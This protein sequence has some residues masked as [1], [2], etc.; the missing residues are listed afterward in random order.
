MKKLFVFALL[1]TGVAMQALAGS[2]PAPV[3]EIGTTTAVGALTLVSGAV[4]VLR[5]RRRK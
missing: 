1:L 4:L 3:P 2:P 5:S